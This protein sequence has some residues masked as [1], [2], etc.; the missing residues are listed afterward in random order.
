MSRLAYFLS[1]FDS[2]NMC[3]R[4]EICKKSNFSKKACAPGGPGNAKCPKVNQYCEFGSGRNFPVIVKTSYSS[5][6]TK[7]SDTTNTHLAPILCKKGFLKRRPTLQSVSKNWS[8]IRV[9]VVLPGFCADRTHDVTAFFQW[10]VTFLAFWI[11][12]RFFPRSSQKCGFT[13][14]RSQK[15]CENFGGISTRCLYYQSRAKFGNCVRL[16]AFLRPNTRSFRAERTL[17][18]TLMSEMFLSH[19]AFGQSNYPVKPLYCSLREQK[20]IPHTS[21]K[22]NCV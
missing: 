14:E 4:V 16:M 11:H 13:T 3:K 8:K 6:A 2:G 15:N 20:S 9:R 5:G 18:Q 21:S 22:S 19:R 7:N 10:G 1:R 12:W 17:W